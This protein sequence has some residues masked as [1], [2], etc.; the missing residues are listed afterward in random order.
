MKPNMDKLQKNCNVPTKNLTTL[1]PVYFMHAKEFSNRHHFL[2][3]FGASMD[4]LSLVYF[5]SVLKMTLLFISD[6]M[7]YCC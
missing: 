3:L 4:Q 5:Q 6:H 7:V 1:E 2:Y